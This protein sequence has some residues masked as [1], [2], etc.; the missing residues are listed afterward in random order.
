MITSFKDDETRRLHETGSSRRFSAIARVALRKLI[1][2]DAAGELSDLR[3]PPGNRLEA[4]QGNLAGRYSIRI[5]DQWRL[6]FRW[7]GSDASEVEICDYH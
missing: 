2:L 6:C 7:D 4:L 3:V 5:N 1:Q